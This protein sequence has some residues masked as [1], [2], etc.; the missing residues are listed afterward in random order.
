MGRIIRTTHPSRCDTNHVILKYMFAPQLCKFRYHFKRDLVRLDKICEHF[1]VEFI[2]RFLGVR[3]T[4]TKVWGSWVP[5]GESVEKTRSLFFF[6]CFRLIFNPSHQISHLSLRAAVFF[7]Y[8]QKV[9]SLPG[10]MALPYAKIGFDYARRDR[11]IVI[12]KS[13]L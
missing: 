6:Y 11:P 10:S 8:G 7:Q 13:W 5:W 4:R 3:K 12:S 1:Y 2:L 9:F